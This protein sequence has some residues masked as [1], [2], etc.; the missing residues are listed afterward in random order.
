MNTTVL[1]LLLAFSSALAFSGVLAADS[2]NL[3]VG[4]V[5]RLMTKDLPDLSGKGRHGR[6]RRLRSRRGLPAP[7][8]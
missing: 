4:K 2:S 1:P 6:N 8:T 5:T 7:S 3:Q